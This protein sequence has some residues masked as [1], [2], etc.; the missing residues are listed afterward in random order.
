M[1]AAMPSP[2]EGKKLIGHVTHYFDKI[3]VAII[4]AESS[5]KEGDKLWIHTKGGDFEQ[6]VHS[7][8]MEHKP[9]SEVGK[10]QSFGLKVDKPVREKDKVYKA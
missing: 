10:G 8:Q 3:G 9:V 4:E 6:T 2:A 5:I 7:M 1:V